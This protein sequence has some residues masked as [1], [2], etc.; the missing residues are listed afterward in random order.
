MKY[1]TLM[2]LVGGLALD[3]RGGP[4]APG[5]AGIN[6][7]QAND[8]LAYVLEHAPRLEI[9]EGVPKGKL[10]LDP[11]T[12][13]DT[14][15]Q[16]TDQWVYNVPQDFWPKHRMKLQR[17]LGEGLFQPWREGKSCDGFQADY[18]IAMP[19]ARDTVYLLFSAGCQEARI[20]REGNALGANAR[21]A[22]FRLTTDLHHKKFEELRVLL[23][24]YRQEQTR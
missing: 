17:L 19:T 13:L 5:D 9:Y 15:L 18:V 1:L 8:F 6:F 7:A 21:G 22:D 2:I 20:V 4:E 16:I 23:T 11:K 24:I 10:P 14:C 3:L 12:R